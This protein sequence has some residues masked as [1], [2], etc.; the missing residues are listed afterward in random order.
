MTFFRGSWFPVRVPCRHQP[1]ERC[2]FC[3]C[4]VIRLVTEYRDTAESERWHCS[5]AQVGSRRS[6]SLALADAVSGLQNN[7]CLKKYV[8]IAMPK[9]QY[10]P[11]FMSAGWRM[12]ARLRFWKLHESLIDLQNFCHQQA[13]GDLNDYCTHFAS[14]NERFSINRGMC[15]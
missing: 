11:V 7:V 15:C 5:Y 10:T 6:G 2:H 3:R 13:N 14:F 9:E 8:S 1:G 12:C 4:D